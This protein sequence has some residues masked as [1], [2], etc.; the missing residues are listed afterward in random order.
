MKEIKILI[1]DDHPIFLKG[2]EDI[3]QSENQFKVIGKAINGKEVLDILSNNICDIVILDIDMPEMNGFECSKIISEK[4]LNIN[5]ILLTMHKKKV[6]LLKALESG[7]SGYV[8]KDSTFTDII[9]CIKSVSN[10]ENYISSAISDFLKENKSIK[11]NFS[12]DINNPR[13]N[14]LYLLTD[15]EIKILNM[16][17]DYK[18]T[19]EIADAL[20]ISERTVSNHR[21][22]ISKKLDLKG[23]NG[24][25]KFLL[26]N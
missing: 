6:F 17:G 8:I 26:Q 23:K 5:I 22:N 16:I 25:L 11:N 7:I 15:M 4:Y 1:A 18:S 13:Q 14:Y 20:F 19:K 24:I 10:N 3:I 12:L 2:L 21:M 9:D